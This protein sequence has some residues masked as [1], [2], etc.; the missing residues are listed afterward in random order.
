MTQITQTKEKQKKF[1]FWLQAKTNKRRKKNDPTVDRHHTEPR[2]KTKGQT[3]N[4]NRRKQN[5]R[6]N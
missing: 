2:H 1:T 5:P 6:L 3:A 4:C